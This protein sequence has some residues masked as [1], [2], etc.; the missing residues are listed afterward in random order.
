MKAANFPS[1]TSI[2]DFFDTVAKVIQ[3]DKETSK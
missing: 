3:Y 2:T 1:H